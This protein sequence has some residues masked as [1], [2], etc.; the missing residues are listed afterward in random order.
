MIRSLA[1]VIGMCVVLLAAGTTPAHACSCMTSGPACQAF[2]KTSAVFDATVLS[3]EPDN[4]DLSPNIRIQ[5]SKYIVK[6][7]VRQR[8][9]GVDRGPLEVVTAGTSASCG[10]DF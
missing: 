9:K 4:R 7:D 6:L 10:F 1:I 5:I 3:I 2:W 8:W